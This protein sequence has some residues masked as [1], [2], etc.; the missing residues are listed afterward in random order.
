MIKR[1]ILII[2][3]FPKL[4]LFTLLALVCFLSY[5]IQYFGIDASEETLINQ[6]DQQ[7]ITAEKIKKKYNVSQPLFIIYEPK[8][9]IFSDSGIQLVKEIKKSLL[10][11][12]AV[13]SAITILDVPLLQGRDDLQLN[14]SFPTLLTTGVSLEAAKQALTSNPFYQNM[15]ISKDAKKIIFQINL[16]PKV[17]KQNAINEIR[18]VV[19]KYK[20]TGIIYL[21]GIDFI[22]DDIMHFIR[23]DLVFFSVGVLITMILILG[24]VFRRL[25]WVSLPMIACIFSVIVMM[26]LLGAMGWKVTIISSNFISL[27]IILTLSLVIHLVIKYIE[28]ARN[29][30]NL[31]QRA[32]IK[33]TL[34]Q[35]IIPSL[36]A[37]LTTIIGFASLVVS[38]I[39]PVM[40]FGWMMMVG[41]VVSLV[42][43]FTLFGSVLNIIPN[44]IFSGH[45]KW[46]KKTI[47]RIVNFV[48]NQKKKIL[49]AMAV[50][51]FIFSYGISRLTVENS[52][53]NYFS[54]STDIHKSLKY[55]DQNL[56]G[57]TPMDIV[58]KLGGQG[59]K[60]DTDN[61]QNTDEFD[62]FSDS[63]ME[64]NS[65]NHYWLTLEKAKMIKKAHDYLESQT[66]IGKVL[67]LWTTLAVIEQIYQRPLNAFELMLLGNFIP[68]EYKSFLWDPYISIS[69]NQ[70][71]ITT[72]IYDSLP[73]IR[74]NEMIMRI[75][76]ELP[77]YL[78]LS[79]ESVTL[80]G[81][82]VLY[83]NMLQALFSSQIKSLGVVLIAIML[84]LLV[85]FRSFKLAIIAIIPN[86][87]SVII[88]LGLM[89]L[90][91]IPLDMMTTTIAAITIGIAVDNAI[92]YIYRFK[93]EFNQHH[94]YNIAIKNTHHSIGIAMIYT[95]L[96]VSIGFGML[97][98]SNFI[99]NVMFGLLT[100]MAMIIALVSGL[101]LLP[102]WLS[103]LKPFKLEK[104]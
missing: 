94:S 27:Q 78:G 38:D 33:E 55:I 22:A 84:M 52:F 39:Y 19:A 31:P 14:K 24:L 79:K 73:N 40:T 72:R 48:I 104:K 43:T 102:V 20:E 5:F 41:I 44:F 6:S 58:I 90:L 21:G 70:F 71:R 29:Q 46:I 96:A 56:G 4:T 36:Y 16:N 103:L 42:I 2:T 99:P 50:S 13:K 62:E 76:E 26:G 97:V 3:H 49:I 67:S 80:T 61:R 18:A 8:N 69:D 12:N 93:K 68:Q 34:S 37:V 57:T 30:P 28:I 25:A 45:N 51:V 75:Q 66:E 88:V 64:D 86:L 95:S 7:Y 65:S 9:S 82:M 74:R 15:L 35:K 60:E 100:A 92:H 23:H 54:E 83:N 59:S 1:F 81:P 53:I 89:G 91:K 32:M 11:K 101:T 85:L 98:F 10:Q 77:A 63:F 17:P 87:L 47:E